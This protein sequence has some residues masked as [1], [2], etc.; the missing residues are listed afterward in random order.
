MK[1]CQPQAR[2]ES[3]IIEDREMPP[4]VIEHMFDYNGW[5]VARWVVR[6]TPLLV[7]LLVPR[8]RLASRGARRPGG[9][10]WVDGTGADRSRRLLRPSP[11]R[12]SRPQS[13]ARYDRRRRTHARTRPAA[14]NPWPRKRRAPIARGANPVAAPRPARRRPRGLREPRRT[15]LDRSIAR[16]QT[17]RAPA[18]RRHRGEEQRADRAL[19]LAQRAARAC[20]ARRQRSG[21]GRRRRAVARSLSGCVLSRTAA[22]RTARGRRAWPSLDASGG[23][24]GR[25]VRRNQRRR[26]RRA[27]RRAARRR[28]AVR[29]L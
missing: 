22:S 16:P 13:R 28:A 29:A 4:I 10:A 27:R 11:L 24:A 5:H 2:S 14:Q 12:Q 6:G 23:D 15:R 26:L 9:D 25:A 21:R 8:G 3:R 17:R 7:E 20:A 1:R 19:G 18:A